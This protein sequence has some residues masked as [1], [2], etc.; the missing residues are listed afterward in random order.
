MAHDQFASP[1]CS[2]QRR[3]FVVKITHPAVTH[4]SASSSS[5]PVHQPPTE[6]VL[7]LADS[8]S[9]IDDV[10]SLALTTLFG[11]LGDT[12]GIGGD[13]FAL[14][15]LE[16]NRLVVRR[17]GDRLDELVP[18]HLNE[19]SLRLHLRLLIPQVIPMI[20]NTMPA[21]IFLFNDIFSNFRSHEWQLAESSCPPSSSADGHKRDEIEFMNASRDSSDT[22]YSQITSA[23][24]INIISLSLFLTH[25]PY[26]LVEDLPIEYCIKTAFSDYGC[27]DAMN[28]D[29]GRRTDIF[30][31]IVALWNSEGESNSS[32]LLP[33]S[34]QKLSAVDKYLANVLNS[35]PLVGQNLFS[36]RTNNTTSSHSFP[37]DVILGVGYE[38][39]KVFSVEKALLEEFSWE[40]CAKWGHNSSFF[41]VWVIAKDGKSGVG[42]GLPPAKDKGQPTK[43][44]NR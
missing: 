37:S 40:E 4:T 24:I 27:E 9:L 32:E 16:G 7:T 20:A 42:G 12:D 34:S 5:S 29:I 17:G 3:A 22:A 19:L 13:V 10:L 30:E 25:G 6:T 21:K 1:S 38:G 2:Q 26:H 36:A 28:V 11:W 15:Q 14:T 41:Y 8:D 43:F 23:Q 31:Q 35:S 18:R 39:L 44:V 33:D